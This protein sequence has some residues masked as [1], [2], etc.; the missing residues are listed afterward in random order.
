V[1]EHWIPFIRAGYAKDGGS[2]LEKTLSAG[3][4]YQSVP[5]GNQLG[6]A[7]NWGRPNESTWGTGLDDQHTLEAFYRIQ[8]WKEFAV[9]PDI[10]YIRN[11]AL[12]PVDDSLWVFGLRARLAF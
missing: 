6:I 7:Y 3:F 11:P 4:A 9:T 10:Q 2:L 1:S 12:N 8:L 5:G